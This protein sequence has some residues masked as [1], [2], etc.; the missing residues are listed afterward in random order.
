MC[1]CNSSSRDK[2]LS[3]L[4]SQ[5]CLLVGDP[6]VDAPASEM[7]ERDPSQDKNANSVWHM[8]LC[9]SHSNKPP[10]YLAQY[11]F[12]PIQLVAYLRGIWRV[13]ELSAHDSNRHQL[14]SSATPD[15][16]LMCGSCVQDHPVRFLVP[17]AV[18]DYIKQH[19][20]YRNMDLKK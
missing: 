3:L 17:Q 1:Q 12:E 4:S 20:L 16:D 9:C 10:A 5:D 11:L 19:Q 8:L 13:H 2:G 15:W 7:H 18:T 14:K 6:E